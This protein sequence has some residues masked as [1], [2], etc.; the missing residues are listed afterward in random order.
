MALVEIN[1]KP[2]SKEVRQFAGLCLVI[3]G[4]M[5]A[6]SWH[7]TGSIDTA[8]WFWLA[9]VAIG[10]TGLA[11]PAL[12]RPLYVAWLMAAFPIGWTVSHVLLGAI[13]FLVLT[14]FGLIVRLTGHD[15]MHRKFEPE[16][17]TYWVEHRT[18]TEPGSYFRQ[19]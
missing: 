7:K 5:G 4:L 6:W 3:F 13:Y 19:F 12:V 15:P 18:G 10:G 14:P 9:A 16:S 2:T 1:W 17:E 8:R 11:M